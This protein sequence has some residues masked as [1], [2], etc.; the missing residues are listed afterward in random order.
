MQILGV[1]LEMYP[2]RLTSSFFLWEGSHQVHFATPSVWCIWDVRP[3]DHAVHGCYVC[4]VENVYMMIY[5]IHIDT[6]IYVIC[7]CYCVQM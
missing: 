2:C 3:T 6:C 4:A 1:F 7:E 5:N